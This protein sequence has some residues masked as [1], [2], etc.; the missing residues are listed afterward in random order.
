MCFEGRELP[1]V[2]ERVARECAWE[3]GREADTDEIDEDAS[4][5]LGGG[6]REDEGAVWVCSTSVCWRKGRLWTMIAFSSSSAG[7][8]RADG[9]RSSSSSSSASPP[10]SSS[11][12]VSSSS[13]PLVLS[14][15]SCARSGGSTE[16]GPE[17]GGVGSA[18]DVLAGVLKLAATDG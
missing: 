18:V 17:S 7:E 10:S 4:L 6:E 9:E 8:F 12:S 15:S 16:S 2:R 3:L 11:S 13:F 14:V 1:R 5:F